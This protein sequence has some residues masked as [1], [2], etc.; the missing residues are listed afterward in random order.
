VAHALQVRALKQTTNT[1]ANEIAGEKFKLQAV[2]QEADKLRG[3]I[4]EVNIVCSSH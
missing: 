2:R 3:L 1:V 4:V